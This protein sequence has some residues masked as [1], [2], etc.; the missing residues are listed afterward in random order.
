MRDHREQFRLPVFN[1]FKKVNKVDLT[2]LGA[3]V[4]PERD[5]DKILQEKISALG[6]AINRL[7]LLQAH[8]ALCLW[9]KTR[10]PCQ[11]FSTS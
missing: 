5:I 10:S 1:N 9:K 6:R 11:N 2:L 4:L 8:D 3:P 7:S